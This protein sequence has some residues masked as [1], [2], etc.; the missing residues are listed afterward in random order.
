MPRTSLEP[1][2]TGEVLCV[3]GETYIA[4]KWRSIRHCNLGI[5]HLYFLSFFL[6]MRRGNYGSGLHPHLRVKLHVFE[7][8]QG[9]SADSLSF[10]PFSLM[11]P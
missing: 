9:A 3:A 10:H 1:A 6:H 4:L 5:A 11:P 2:H 8:I 7:S